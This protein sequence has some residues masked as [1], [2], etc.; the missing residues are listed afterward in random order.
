MVTP[1]E[2]VT[3]FLNEWTQGRQNDTVYS[4]YSPSNKELVRLEASDL[5]ALVE[6]NRAMRTRLAMERINK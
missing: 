1:D 3:A 4:L 2:R 5:R 6:E